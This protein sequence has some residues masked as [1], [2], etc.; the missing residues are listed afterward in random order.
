ME[1][2]RNDRKPS[3]SKSEEYNEIDLGPR[4]FMS[5]AQR[6]EADMFADTKPKTMTPEA[7]KLQRRYFVAEDEWQ[8]CELLIFFPCAPLKQ[9]WDFMMMVF[10]SYACIVMPYRSVFEEAT[11]RWFIFETGILFVFLFDVLLTFNT[12]YLEA[13]L[14]GDNWVIDRGMIMRNY[15]QGRFVIEFFGA[16]PAELVDL[17]GWEAEDDNHTQVAVL[18]ALRLLRLLRVVRVLRELQAIY[19]DVLVRLESRLQT[20]LAGFHLAGPLIMLIYTSAR[21]HTQR[22]SKP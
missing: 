6:L 5:E 17:A 11:G 22:G 2:L 18:R 12:A 9:L 16:Y 21:A 4:R 19:A 8:T 15:L 1:L 7:R 14:E 13:H 20:N 3:I 10:V